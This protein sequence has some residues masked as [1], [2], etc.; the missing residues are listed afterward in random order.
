[1]ID[2]VITALHDAALAP[3]FHVS[4]LPDGV[5][6]RL[7]TA[8]SAAGPAD[9]VLAAIEDR[10]PYPVLITTAD[11]PLLSADMVRDFVAGSEASGADFCV[12]LAEKTVIQP[13]YPDVKRTYLNF[14][15]R[16]VSG[17]NLFYVANAK[18]LAAI[19][20][21]SRAQYYRKRPLK[22][23]AQFGLAVF[24]R[25]FTG[26]LS[27]DGAFIFAAK[28]MKITTAPILLPFAEA[29]IDVDK[30]ADKQLVEQILD[31]RLRQSAQ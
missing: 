5:D 16:S 8:P 20:F 21:W 18:G 7:R 12:G 10:M 6:D 17:C 23:A 1:M 19:R 2:Y 3:P 26:R 25:Y 15:D 30:P 11:H 24:W 9:S 13:A 14:S 29:A 4:G 22:L 27:L 31:T 28:T